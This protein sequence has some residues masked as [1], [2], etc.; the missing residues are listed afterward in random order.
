MSKNKNEEAINKSTYEA[1]KIFEPSISY[2]K[3]FNWLARSTLY[4]PDFF[5]SFRDIPFKNDELNV[6]EE[7]ETHKLQ[8]EMDNDEEK[9]FN[10]S[11]SEKLTSYFK[12]KK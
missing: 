9:P 6:G 10:I 3:E 1:S 12:K 8:E 11:F 7:F 2:N 4:V 5:N